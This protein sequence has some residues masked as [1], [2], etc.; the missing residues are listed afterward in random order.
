PA[1]DAPAGGDLFDAP[2]A[3]A[4][5][6]GDLFDAPA[7]DAPAGGDLFDPPAGGDL[8]DDAPA[9]AN[10]AGDAVGQ[11]TST[12]PREAEK[13]D[14]DDLFG[15]SDEPES[16][17]EEPATNPI[18]DLFGNNMRIW[19]DNTGNFAVEAQLAE[20]RTDSVRLLKSNG[21]YCTVPM[22]RLSPS[23]KLLV[24]RVAAASGKKTVKF[25]ST[26]R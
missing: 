19:H 13:L 16:P 1:A 5:A 24:H 12:N 23:D 8:F 17:E 26:G 9:S 7:A 14:L 22:R 10:N 20:I 21:K 18:D 2:A 25:I 4:P 11:P 6:G 3:D 15:P